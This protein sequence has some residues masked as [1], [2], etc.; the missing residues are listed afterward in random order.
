MK[1]F[2]LLMVGLS[3]SVLILVFGFSIYILIIGLLGGLM[4]SFA[5][6]S[7]L[8]SIQNDYP[9]GSDT[10]ERSKYF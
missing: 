4:T 3:V 5:I 1:W 7:K 8:K 10:Y 9:G 2:Y 6:A